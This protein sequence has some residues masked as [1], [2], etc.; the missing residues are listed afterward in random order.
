MRTRSRYN[1]SMRLL[2]IGL[3]LMLCQTRPVAAESV[4]PGPTDFDPEPVLN[5]PQPVLPKPNA[6]DYYVEAAK[7]LVYAKP[8]VDP[9]H[10]TQPAPK[11]PKEYAK[12]YAP[13][14]RNTYLQKNAQALALLREGFKY[15]YR[16]PPV[17]SWATPFPY[18]GKLREVARL[19]L[20]ESRARQG[21]GQW[22]AAADST[23]DILR[24][25]TDLPRGG[26]L[27]SSLFGNA[28]QAM[29]QAELWHIVPHLAAGE[30]GIVAS[31]LE[32]IIQRRVPFEAVLRE[33]KWQ[34]L[35]ELQRL[36]KT[37]NW[38]RTIVLL[39]EQQDGT[40]P[41]DE[42]DQPPQAGGVPALLA[43]W[44]KEARRATHERELEAYTRQTFFA[45]ASLQLDMIIER[46]RL[47]YTQMRSSNFTPTNS[48]VNI[49]ASTLVMGDYNHARC[50]TQNLL[51]M[52][53]LALAAYKHQHA[54]Y[55][56]TL[57]PLIP[58]YLHRV[59]LDP[60][61]NGEPL[62]YRLRDGKPLLWSIG[63]DGIDN[64]G[65]PI[66]NSTPREPGM[67]ETRKRRVLPDSKGDIV[68]GVNR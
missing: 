54:R 12:R 29:G 31:K 8:Q 60:F 49:I 43:Y 2:I 23:L 36:L 42:F 52:V 22:G 66:D 3:L 37:P 48:F 56:D 11:D 68:A 47:P 20:V 5:I 26:T 55:P 15:E 59:P 25:G 30:A 32:E 67:N 28:I 21:R 57:T 39:V 64:G 16:H 45:E 17:R 63:P 51:L 35:A 65:T 46:A 61:G 18:Y 34:D 62:R 14:A 38:R 44:S 13:A 27:I 33:S 50:E 40:P 10:D 58:D 24:L 1:M 41:D 7:V 53:T 4:S 9:V 6:Y 19:L